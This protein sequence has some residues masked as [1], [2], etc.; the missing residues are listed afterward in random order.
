MDDKT[1]AQIIEGFEIG[2]CVI[3]D[4][5]INEYYLENLLQ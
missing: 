4:M 3:R 1:D 5:I 2:E